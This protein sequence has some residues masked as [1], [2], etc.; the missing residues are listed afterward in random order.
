MILLRIFVLGIA[1][2]ALAGCSS[3]SGTTGPGGFSPALSGTASSSG[4]SYIVTEGTGS[5]VLGPP[6]GYDP[7]ISMSWW[8]SGL[9]T[10][11]GYMYSD[12]NV[13]AIAGMK[14]SG[15]TFAG[16]SGAPAVGLPTSGSALYNGAFSA[17]YFRLGG[18]YQNWNADGQLS[19][20]V[21]FSNGTVLGSGTG[22]AGSQLV[23]NGAITGSR[24]NGSAN[25]SALDYGGQPSVPMTGGFFGYGTMAGIFKGSSVAGVFYGR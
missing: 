6:H 4:T 23:I 5:T 13:R 8:Y 2:A 14:S 15:T 19:T 21:D 17:T 7:T 1:M 22:T 25:F 16:I 3:R 24:F 20:Y 11:A 12:G 18:Y 10:P 9:A